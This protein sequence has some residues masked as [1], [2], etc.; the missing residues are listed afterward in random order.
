MID[1]FLSGEKVRRLFFDRKIVANAVPL[2]LPPPL[3]VNQIAVGPLFSASLQ[4]NSLRGKP[5][6]NK[7]YV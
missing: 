7:Q 2:L 4:S 1:C 3:R 5:G 6:L